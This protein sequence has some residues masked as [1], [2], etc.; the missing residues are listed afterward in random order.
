MKNKN[1]REITTKYLVEN[2]YDGL[3]QEETGECAC[4]LK[5][6]FWHCDGTDAMDCQAGYKTHCDSKCT[7]GGDCDFHIIDTKPDIDQ[8]KDTSETKLMRH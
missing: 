4:D 3:W 5:N 2:G 7:F 8:Q 6:L 1:I